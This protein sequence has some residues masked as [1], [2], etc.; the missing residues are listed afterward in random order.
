MFSEVQKQQKYKINFQK[1]F[2]G[3][4]NN[5]RGRQFSLMPTPE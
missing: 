4:E 2:P 3:I 5:F 1:N